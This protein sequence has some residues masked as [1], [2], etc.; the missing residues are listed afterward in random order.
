MLY[1][2]RVPFRR[3]HRNPLAGSEAGFGVHVAA[4]CSFFAVFAAVVA[5]VGVDPGCVRGAHQAPAVE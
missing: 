4:I 5:A 1:R 2:G 3:H